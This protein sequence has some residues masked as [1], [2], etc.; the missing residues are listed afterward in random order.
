MPYAHHPVRNWAGPERRCGRLARCLVF[1]AAVAIAALTFA[2]T[3]ALAAAPAFDPPRSG[4]LRDA[5]HLRD[6]YRYSASWAGRYLAYLRLRGGD[7]QTPVTPGAGDP[8]ISD[9]VAQ[10]RAG[11]LSVVRAAL[12][13]PLSPKPITISFERSMTPDELTVVAR[14]LHAGAPTEILTR[15]VTPNNVLTSGIAPDAP[16]AIGTRATAGQ[17]KSSIGSSLAVIDSRAGENVTRLQTSATDARALAAADP[18]DPH[19]IGDALEAEKIVSDYSGLRLAIA[20][21]KPIVTAF[22]VKALPEAVLI[23]ALLPTSKISGASIALGAD[24]GAASG[25][26][27]ILPIPAALRGKELEVIARKARKS[28]TAT[29][30]RRARSARARRLANGY[31]ASGWAPSRYEVQTALTGPANAAG[32]HRKRIHMLWRWTQPGTL[33]EY[34][35]PEDGGHGI[36]MQVFPTEDRRFGDKIWSTGW[37]APLLGSGKQWESTAPNAYLD[38]ITYDLDAGP[39]DAK[40]RPLFA[41]GI[42]SDGARQLQMGKLYTGWYITD[43]GERDDGKV[44]IEP[45]LSRREARGVKETGYCNQPITGW[46]ASACHFQVR[47]IEVDRTLPLRWSA[48]YVCKL[49]VNAACKQDSLR[50]TSGAPYVPPPIVRFRAT[51]DSG[52]ALRLYVWDREGHV[53]DSFRYSGAGIP[54]ASLGGDPLG[55][56]LTFTEYDQ[57]GRDYTIGLCNFRADSPIWIL[58]TITDPDGDTRSQPVLLGNQRGDSVVFNSPNGPIAP[59]SADWCEYEPPDDPGDGPIDT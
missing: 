34:G 53:A 46:K 5:D 8:A 6:C 12:D 9:E 17:I 35:T 19:A 57:F 25:Q 27:D 43:E 29:K 10:A 56:E 15:Y 21:Q 38:D 50:T 7:W 3:P 11:W 23:A 4:C 18:T 40:G 16:V 31:P 41:I 42:G 22:T 44:R 47:P 20:Q 45:E 14:A 26:A 52:D 24:A 39:A 13:E 48:H 1:V 59:P 28:G 2:G 32:L 36:E 33:A 37:Y 51:W 49:A 58:T 55:G 54:L 30:K